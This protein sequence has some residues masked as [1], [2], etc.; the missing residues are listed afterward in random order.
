MPVEENSTAAVSRKPPRRTSRRPS[1]VAL[2]QTGLVAAGFGLSSVSWWFLLLVGAAAVGPGLLRELG[3]LR[4]QDEFARQA[5]RRAGYHA[6]LAGLAIMFVFAAIFRTET[7]VE[8]EPGEMAEL[9]LIVLWFTW[10]LSWLLSYWGPRK[11]AARVL[12]A[13][14]AVWLLFNVLANLTSSVALIMQSLL[15]VPFFVLG[16]MAGR[17]PRPAGVLLILA[18]I[19]FASMFDTLERVFSTDP[20]DNGAPFVLVLFIG[21]LLASGIA[22]LWVRRGEEAEDDGNESA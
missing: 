15:A 13:F 19:W 5:A 14:G 12:Y 18:S 16:W 4:D 17:W 2:V 10:L 20:F 9:A 3:V 22:L 1:P 8:A 7:P 11:M 21:P 6:Y